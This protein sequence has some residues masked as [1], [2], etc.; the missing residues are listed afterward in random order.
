MDTKRSDV[1]VVGGGLIG[2]MI[3]RALAGEGLG[4]TLVERAKVGRE[5]SHD[6]AGM[7]APVAEAE[8]AGPFLDLCLESRALYPALADELFDEVGG[9]ISYRDEGTFAVAFDE[10]EE[11]RLYAAAARHA[12]LGLKSEVLSPGEARHVEPGLSP[13]VR[14]V[15]VVADDHQVDNR[16]LV[17]AVALSCFKRGVEILEHTPVRALVR[18]AAGT[19]CGVETTT[20]RIDAGLVVV[21]AG[22]WSNFVAGFTVPV[23]PVKG[24]MLMLDLASPAFRH[25]L[26][27]ER[28][29]LVPRTDGRVLVGATMERVGYDKTVGAGAVGTLLESGREIVPSLAVALG[30]EAWAGLRPATPDGIPAVGFVEERVIAAT[31]HFRNGILLAPVTAEIV[32][33]L[34]TGKP[35]HAALELLD[36]L[37][38][39]R[40]DG[41]QRA[42]L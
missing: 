28:C 1:V 7:L 42:Q 24:Q 5:A 12:A 2:C 34:A 25:V 39:A 21:A 26:R 9:N 17:E 30:G 11:A 31:G 27:S 13:R 35:G 32:R 18:D 8:E 10:A 41:G 14:R 36:P 37:R 16:R 15:L 3:A 20:G 4:V 22:S 6:A 38:F 19:V 33:G 23:A 40:H 29:Y